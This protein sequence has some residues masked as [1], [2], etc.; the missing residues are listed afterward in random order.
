MGSESTQ[1]NI[2]GVHINAAR[3]D[4]NYAFSTTFVIT[5]NQNKNMISSYHKYDVE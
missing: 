2:N 4:N 3:L 1:E 5:Q